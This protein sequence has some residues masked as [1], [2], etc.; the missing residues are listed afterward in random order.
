MFNFLKSYFHSVYNNKKVA[1]LASLPS[2]T[3]CLF[4]WDSK[5]S[6]VILS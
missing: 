6:E 1:Q 3:I 5:I 4:F 2:W